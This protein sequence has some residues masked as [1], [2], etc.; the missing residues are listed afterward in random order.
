MKA[1]V[2]GKWSIYLKHGESEL[3]I[4]SLGGKCHW[5]TLYVLGCCPSGASTPSLLQKLLGLQDHRARKGEDK[6]NMNLAHWLVH[7]IIR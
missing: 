3:N 2:P 6:P 4:V 5:A 1:A 7:L